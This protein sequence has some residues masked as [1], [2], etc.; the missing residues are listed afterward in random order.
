MLHYKVEINIYLCFNTYMCIFK[1]YT[2]ICVCIIWFLF[3]NKMNFQGFDKWNG[4]GKEMNI[5][6]IFKK[7]NHFNMLL[8]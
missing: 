2:H 3:K 6:L 8:K 1:T 7:K 5:L 4:F